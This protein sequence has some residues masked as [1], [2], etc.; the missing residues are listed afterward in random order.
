M[1]S[2][3]LRLF[4]PYNIPQRENMNIGTGITLLILNLHTR[5]ESPGTHCRS[6]WVVPMAGLDGSG[7]ENFSGHKPEPSSL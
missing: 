5:L 2:T 1:L 6:D 3:Y 4:S 7:G